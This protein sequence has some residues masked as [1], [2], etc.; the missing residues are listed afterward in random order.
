MEG[1]GLVGYRVWRTSRVALSTPSVRLLYPSGLA[2]L[3]G[4]LAGI[5]WD[6]SWEAEVLSRTEH[7]EIWGFDYAQEGFGPDIRSMKQRTHFRQLQLGPRDSHGPDDDP[8]VYTLQTLMF[9]NG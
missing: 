7:C 5:D 8:K 2:C 3:I 6:S 1:S 9:E 4:R